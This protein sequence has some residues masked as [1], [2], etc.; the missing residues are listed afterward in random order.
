MHMINVH[1]CWCYLK[2]LHFNLYNVYG[3]FKLWR[4]QEYFG[5]KKQRKVPH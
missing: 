4:P 5:D 1:V 2:E 3:E